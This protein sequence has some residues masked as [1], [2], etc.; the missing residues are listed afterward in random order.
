MYLR[1]YGCF[2]TIR[3][4]RGRRNALVVATISIYLVIVGA[5]LIL[6]RKIPSLGFIRILRAMIRRPYQAEL[7]DIR[8]E[9]SACFIAN[10]PDSLLSDLESVSRLVVFEDGR[11]LG[12]GHASHADI[13]ALG[14]GRYSHW[15]G[16]VYFSTSDNSDPRQNGRRYTVEE[17]L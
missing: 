6:T 16:E 15:G 7:K 17:M 3:T 2:M 8:D 12:P 1:H 14:Y 9:R 10:V 13:R 4:Q 5:W 11:P